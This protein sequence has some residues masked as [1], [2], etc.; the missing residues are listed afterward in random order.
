MNMKFGRA[1]AFI[2]MALL[3]STGWVR[4]QSASVEPPAP[5]E[6]GDPAETRTQEVVVEG[7]PIEESVLPT[8]RPVSSI[9]GTDMNILDTPRNA[10]IFNANELREQDIQSIEQISRIVPSAYSPSRWGTAS[11]PQFRGDTGQVYING[12]RTA[13]NSNGIPVNF[14]PVESLD[15]VPG[16]ASVVFG[17]GAQVGGYVNLVTKAPYFDKFQGSAQLSVGTFDK[18]NW[19]LDFGAPII[20]NELAYRI[21]YEGQEA[22]DYY[23]NVRHDYETVFASMSWMPKGSKFKLDVD[24]SFYEITAAEVAGINRPTQALIDDGRYITGG[25][26]G[27]GFGEATTTPGFLGLVTPTGVTQINLNRVIASPADGEYGRNWFLQAAASYEFSDDFKLTN[28]EYV[29]SMQRK[30]HS[31]YYYLEYVPSQWVY[32]NRTEFNWHFDLFGWLDGTDKHPDG[33]AGGDENASVTRHGI[34]NDMTFGV[35]YRYEYTRGYTEYYNENYNDFD[36]TQPSNTY[37]TPTNALVDVLPITVNGRPEYADTGGNY[38]TFGPF[39]QQYENNDNTQ[40]SDYHDAGLFWQDNIQFTKWL[41]A[42]VGGRGDLVYIYS[43]DPLPAPGYAADRD[44]LLAGRGAAEA[45]LNYKLVPQDTL[46]VSYDYAEAS[47]GSYIDG[48]YG[49]TG[50]PSK[51]NGASLS[52]TAVHKKSQLYE[53]GNKLSV[54]KDTL[55]LSLAGYYQKRTTPTRTNQDLEIDTYGVEAS[56]VYQPTRHFSA[57]LSGGWLNARYHDLPGNLPSGYV[58]TVDVY[59]TFTPPVGTGVGSP[60]FRAFPTGNYR[61]PDLPDF[62]LNAYAR[63]ALD[64]GLGISGGVTFT[65]PQHLDLLGYT[66][67]HAQYTLNGSLFYNRKWFETRIDFYNIT[68]QVNWS[69]ID[70][71]Y[72]GDLVV[73]EL[74][75]HVLGTVKVNF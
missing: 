64:C 51:G 11:V 49:L 71:V 60:N 72:G 34:G 61:V 48:G 70:P 13:Y 56:G 15:A 66:H 55:F 6:T 22:G 75:F 4:A 29:E 31:D 54:F 9:F 14:N 73:R 16:P 1:P 25:V 2:S 23:Q 74:P 45:S 68:N 28:R 20:K 27:N 50:D 24:G 35:D 63:Y 17:P 65:S 58:S 41:S 7:V 53:T 47:E 44:S 62:T 40:R 36:L 30:K 43:Q 5:T 10:T 26:T 33:K 38:P 3:C 59:D 67:I 37:R 8:S 69:G 12:I 57:N 21:S 18:Y 39:G 19:N 32:E 42:I 52:P 46:Y